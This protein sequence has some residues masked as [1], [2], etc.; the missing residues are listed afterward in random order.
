MAKKLESNFVN[1]FVVLLVI[2]L[3]AALA[4]GFTYSKTRPEIEAAALKK[5]EKIITTVLDGISYDNKPLAEKYAVDGFNGLELYPAKQ[6]GELVGVAVKTVSPSGYSGNVW[7]MVGFKPD[8]TI[9]KTAV[10][11]QKETPGLGTKMDTPWKDQYNGK[12]P[13][14]NNLKVKNEGGEIDAIT[15][16]TISSRAFSEAVQKAYDAFKKGG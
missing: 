2:G 3:V 1:M 5:Q 4:L 15:A 8:G 6:G 9:N 10:L 13:G 16:A 12:N 14:T 11:E 7:L